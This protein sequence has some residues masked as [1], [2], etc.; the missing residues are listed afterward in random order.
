MQFL[1]GK[2]KATL[3]LTPGSA[4]VTFGAGQTNVQVA[5]YGAADTFNFMHG[6][7]GGTDVI[8]SFRFGTDRLAFIGVSVKSTQVSNGGTALTLSDGTHVQLAGVSL[9]AGR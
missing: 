9:P 2:G 4:S 7:G 3:A 8:A 6:L 5:G 1:A